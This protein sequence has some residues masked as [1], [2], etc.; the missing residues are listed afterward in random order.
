VAIGGCLLAA[1]EQSNAV[2]CTAEAAPG[3]SGLSIRIDGSDGDALVVDAELV[4]AAAD[5]GVQIVAESS[6]VII[7]FP[8]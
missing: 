2:R 6:A 7:S 1:I 5:A 8:R 3:V 4:A